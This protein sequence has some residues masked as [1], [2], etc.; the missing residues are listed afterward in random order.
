MELGTG[1]NEQVEEKDTQSLC[2]KESWN[3]VQWRHSWGSL[4]FIYHYSM[5]QEHVQNGYQNLEDDRQNIINEFLSPLHMGAMSR[6]TK[7]TEFE[8]H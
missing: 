3:A 7:G 4:D 8:L 2:V 6:H 5:Q 1:Q